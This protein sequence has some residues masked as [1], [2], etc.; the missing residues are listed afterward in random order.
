MRWEDCGTGVRGR[1]GLPAR[2]PPMDRDR[3]V[4][5][6]RAVDARGPRDAN[7]VNVYDRMAPQMPR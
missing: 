4:R 6:R 3:L 1:L 7:N 5:P 2:A